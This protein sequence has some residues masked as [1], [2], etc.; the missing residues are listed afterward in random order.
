MSLKY[1]MADSGLGI[2]D[3]DARVQTPSGDLVAVEGNGVDLAEM[4]GQSPQASAFGNAPD[5]CGRV[6]ATR[7]DKVSMNTKTSH[8]S[9]VSDKDILAHAGFDIPDSQGGIS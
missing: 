4:A 3:P 6:V 7:N 8:T 2:P 9:L 1:G 5:P